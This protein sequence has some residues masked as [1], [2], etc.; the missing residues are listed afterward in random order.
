MTEAHFLS[1]ELEAVPAFKAR[2]LGFDRSLIGAYG[3]DDRVCAYLNRGVVLTKYTGS[4]GKSGTS[5]ASAE[6]MGFVRRLM[7]G[8]GVSWQICLLYTS[9]P[10]QTSR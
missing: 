9:F 3:H 2:D 6:F 4:K 7:D 5:D 10:R 8:A 1:A